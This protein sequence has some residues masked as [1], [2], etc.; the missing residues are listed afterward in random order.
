MK[1]VNIIELQTYIEQNYHIRYN[2]VLNEYEYRKKTPSIENEGEFDYSEWEEFNEA[3]VV[4]DLLE[5]NYKV[6]QRE[7]EVLLNSDFIE[8]YNP[9]EEYFSGLEKWNGTDD[10]IDKLA[11]YVKVNSIDIERWKTQLKKMFVRSVAT[12]LGITLNK[13][14]LVIVH[15]K[16]N[17]GKTTF[18]RWLAPPALKNYYAENIELNKDGRI[19]LG[20]NFIINIDEMSALSKKDVNELKSILSKAEIKDRL[21]YGKKPVRIPRRCN[22]VGS[23]NRAEFL[24]D[25]TGNVRWVCFQIHSINWEYK[26]DIDINKVWSQSYSLLKQGFKYELNL[27][28]IQENEI[29]NNQFII[30]TEE[31]ELIQKYYE[32]ADSDTYGAKFLSSTEITNELQLRIQIK[33]N[34]LKVTKALKMLGFERKS[35]RNSDKHYNPFKGYYLLEIDLEEVK[36]KEKQ[37]IGIATPEDEK[38]INKLLAIQTKA[39]F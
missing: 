34:T 39:D 20:Q 11:S 4:K 8:R 22:F 33:I 28:E 7:I 30:R 3:N 21:P 35:G 12:G 27:Q 23:T 10:Y 15:E 18:L 26:K 14:A 24:S 9:I 32:P 17:S 29:A 38:E 37:Q 1:Q 6:P 5:H 31:M 16:Q 2:I 19:S 36:M 13:Q 25:E